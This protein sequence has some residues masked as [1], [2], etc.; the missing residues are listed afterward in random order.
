MVLFYLVASLSLGSRELFSFLLSSLALLLF[1][2]PTSWFSVA[3]SEG[4]YAL[5]GIYRKPPPPDLGASCPHYA[6]IHVLEMHVLY[7]TC[8]RA[9]AK[10]KGAML[11]DFS[12]SLERQI[13][14]QLNKIN[15]L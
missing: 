8:D 3:P 2:T 5:S 4:C 6:F 9:D 7:F 10:F 13:C 11:Q 14:F 1:P 15:V 12:V